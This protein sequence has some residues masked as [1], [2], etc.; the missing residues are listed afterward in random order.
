MTMLAQ[1]AAAAGGVLPAYIEDVFST[2]LYTGNGST[3]T[4]TN[5]IDL[6]GE[7]GLVWIKDRTTGFSHR[8]FDTVRGATNSLNTG[9]STEQIAYAT[10]LTAFT[11]SGF[12]LGDFTNTNTS[13]DNFASWTF[14]KQP[15][16]FDVVTW[17]GDGASSRAISHNLG[18]VPGCI[19][20]KT[21]S[22]V[23]NWFTYHRSLNGGINP[24]LWYLLLN[25]TGAQT[26]P[27]NVWGGT[28]PTSTTFSVGSLGTNESGETYV[29]YL[30]AHDAGGFGLSGN[31]NVVSCGSFTYDGTNPTTVNL[32]YEPQ[33][34]LFKNASATG[35]WW[36]FD[37]MRGLTAD[38]GPAYLQP[39]T[40]AAEGVGGAA[41]CTITSTG[42]NA[43]SGNAGNTSI[44]IAI[45]RGPM[46]VPTDG[47]KVYNAIVRN[48][49]QADATVTGVGFPVDL[50]FTS[51]RPAGTHNPVLSDRLRGATKTL[52]SRGAQAEQTEPL[53]LTSFASMDGVS[54]GADN[55]GF[56]NGFNS[57]I[58]ASY[59]NWFFRRAPS[60]FDEVCYTE[61]SSLYTINH[62]LG[63]LPELLIYKVRSS[64]R[65]WFVLYKNPSTGLYD[66]N[67]LLNT[68]DAATIW[69]EPVTAI[70]STTIPAYN[71]VGAGTTDVAYLFATCAGVSKVGSYTG[72]GTTQAI[73]CGFTAG[74]RYVLI[75]RTDDVGDW[76]VWD[77]ARG[78]VAGN[79]PYLQINNTNAEVTGTDY[80]DT[81]AAG[82]E[83][84]STAPAAINASGGSYIFL[85]VA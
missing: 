6:A 25:T 14:R 79:D 49:T 70:T 78:I 13:G 77:S 18:A 8:L 20:S 81:S 61:Q 11:S 35:G 26:N 27:F 54:L 31:E 12:S 76:Y 17:T 21:T 38:S 34:I 73:N 69:Y 64:A 75:K 50:A 40:A 42:F 85:A 56:W 23:G 72:T 58:G 41:L 3:Q 7:G 37:T 5:G 43:S 66:K 30:F 67:L 45:R 22:A 39:N 47:T 24:E 9:A 63:A 80:I 46:K 48:G 32:G 16:F 71:F 74:A 36:M 1:F 83:I 60:F 19:I 52:S 82:F 2:H 57:T 4:I 59:V 44:Y 62:N 15:K 55:T 65:D 51:L 29:A 53:A 10:S 28:P 68:S 84:S 33:F